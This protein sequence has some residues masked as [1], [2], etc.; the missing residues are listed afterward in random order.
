MGQ[1]LDV[2]IGIL[3][4]ATIL[5][6]VAAGVGVAGV[7]WIRRVWRRRRNELALRASGL[8]VTGVAA[9][10]QWL[11]TRSVPD[12]RWWVLQRA[13]RG[14]LRSSTGAEHA[15]REAKAA[16][17]ALGDLEGL[18]RRLRRAAVDVDRT[19]R[20]AQR[21]DGNDAL[22]E[23]LRHSRDLTAAGI[24]IQRAAA[25]SLV[26]LNRQTTHDLVAHVLTEERAMVGHAAP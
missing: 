6:A 14:L 1:V 16:G 3:V 13:R 9:A 24:R 17:A 21:S 7:L 2:A 26:G 11:G 20:I 25:D 18:A 4:A 10:F 15:V 8:A 12:H 19:L 5:T 23:L 22:D